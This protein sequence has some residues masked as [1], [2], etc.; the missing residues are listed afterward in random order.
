LRQLFQLIN[1]LSRHLRVV[2][3]INPHPF[4]HKAAFFLIIAAKHNRFNAFAFKEIYYGFGFGPHL[5]FNI[6]RSYDAVVVGKIKVGLG[7]FIFGYFL[8]KI[9]AS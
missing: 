6:K 1:F 5:V 9:P 4:N 8:Y 7:Y 2:I 3:F